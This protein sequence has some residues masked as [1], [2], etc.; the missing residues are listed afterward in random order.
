ML[1]EFQASTMSRLLL[2]IALSHLSPSDQ[3]EV[4]IMLSLLGLRRYNQLAQTN[5]VDIF[6]LK[7]IYG[8]CHVAAEFPSWTT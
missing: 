7:E 8:V 6:T 5:V 4:M 1:G 2:S 3:D